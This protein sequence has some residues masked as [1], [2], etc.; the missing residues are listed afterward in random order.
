MLVVWLK[1]LTITQKISE[2]EKEITDDN[3]DKYITTPEFNRLITENF[4]ARLKQE[5]LVTKTDFDYKLKYLN[6]KNYFKQNK[7]CSSWK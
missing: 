5:N 2:L 6:K 3:P 1:K 7:T 4:I